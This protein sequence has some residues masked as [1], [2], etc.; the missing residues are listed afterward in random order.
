MERLYLIVVAA[1]EQLEVLSMHTSA[2][3]SIH[4]HTSA[5]LERL[6]LI[7]VAALEL[8]EVLSM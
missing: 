4:Q 6:Y 8:L 5:Y 7:V 1:L 3:V 2:Y